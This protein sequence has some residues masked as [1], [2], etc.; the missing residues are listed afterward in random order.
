MPDPIFCSPA[1][2]QSLI[3]AAPSMVG[4]PAGRTGV[5][6]FA[7]ELLLLLFD[8]ERGD[9]TGALPPG[10]LDVLLAGAV[11]T[12]LA[13]EDRIDTDLRRL[14]LVDPTPLDDDLLDPALADIAQA[15]DSHDIDHW[16]R[17]H[18]DR[19]AVTR[20]RGL[21]RWRR[22][23]SWSPTTRPPVSCCRAA[24][25]ARGGTTRR[26]TAPCRRKSGCGS[27]ACCSA[28]TSRI[29]ATR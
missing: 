28:R 13:L 17:R 14:M 26:R 23:G 24:C 10:R 29:R 27:C 16:V 19:G 5:M 3:L 25:R 15:S 12:D 11:L 22:A 1:R 2:S 6:R 18:A 8:D 9:L 7:E 4:G 21:A 20:E